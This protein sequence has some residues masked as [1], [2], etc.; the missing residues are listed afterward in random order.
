MV[1]RIYKMLSLLIRPIRLNRTIKKIEQAVN[2][3]PDTVYVLNIIPQIGDIC[4]HFA[5][6]KAFKE[7]NPNKQ[8]VVLAHPAHQDVYSSFADSCD[9]IAVL[10]KKA[11]DLLAELTRTHTFKARLLHLHQEKRFINPYLYSYLDYS[12]LRDNY[13]DGSL[14][15]FIRRFAFCLDDSAEITFPQIS[16]QWDDRVLESMFSEEDGVR[17]IF[18]PYANSTKVDLELYQ[19][20]I[21][22]IKNLQLSMYTNCF[23]SETPLPHT[24][25]LE[26]SKGD[27]FRI[28]NGKRVLVIGTRSGIL[29][30]IV[31]TEAQ[32]L[33]ICFNGEFSRLWDLEKWNTGNVESVC[34]YDG[35]YSEAVD[36]I[37]SRVEEYCG[38]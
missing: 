22:R 17:V 18:A 24:Q 30:Y 38:T 12:A 32:I 14:L 11:C 7:H 36:Q 1:K 15:T 28:C 29:D 13:F 26:C 21:E 4:Y 37:V 5:Y 35:K 6:V 10:S 33:S 16:P 19:A 8:V 3:H 31:S 9:R 2:A 25:R 27:L 34:V 23:G 20:I